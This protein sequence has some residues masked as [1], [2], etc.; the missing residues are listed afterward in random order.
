MIS[1]FAIPSNVPHDIDP[2][3]VFKFNFDYLE[4]LAYKS[5]YEMFFK[6]LNAK[7]FLEKTK[8]M[9][10]PMYSHSA[11][12]VHLSHSAHSHSLEAGIVSGKRKCHFKKNVETKYY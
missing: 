8:S 6:I 7:R 1:P 10:S 12:S 11:H 2:P 4:Y 9:Q 3:T 5:K